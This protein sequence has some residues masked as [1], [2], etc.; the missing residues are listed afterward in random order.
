M[1]ITI[2]DIAARAGVS[3][4]TVSR[5]LNNRPEGVGRETRERIE[6][7]LG[8]TG[9]QPSGVARGLAT[10]RSRTI[11]LIIPDI[12]NPFYPLLVRG[13]E[14]ALSKAGYSLLLCNSVASVMREKDYVTLLMEKGVDGVI[15][16]PAES[17]CDCQLA[18]L[19]K[20]GVPFIL[21]DRIIEGR[22]G[23][24]GVFVDNRLGAV[25]AASFLMARDDCSLLFLNGPVDLSPS[26]L[27][28]IGINEVAR[29]KGLPESRLCVRNGDYSLA[30][31]E[32]LLESVLDE[33]AWKPGHAL[34]FNAVFANDMMAVGA[35]R[36]LRRRA[37]KVP[38]E[39]EIIGFDDIELAQLVDPPLSTVAQP[40]MAMGARSAELLLDM[41][42]G[43]APPSEALIMKPQLILRGSTR[44]ESPN[45][46]RSAD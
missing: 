27:R 19:E 1:K 38:E 34:P 36:A 18:M 15:L 20:K 17:D 21:L 28:L 2:A 41:I 31:G 43:N 26:A 24:C 11:G 5:V 6:K 33:A 14:C 46:A 22:A 25:M 45:L 39:V 8:D 35:L 3:K 42:E 37:I 7:I 29:A 9:F 13:V 23:R 4:A 44:P 32:R 12:T 16:D 40:I 10:G 30:S